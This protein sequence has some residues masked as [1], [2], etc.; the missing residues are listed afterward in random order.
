MHKIVEKQRLSEYVYSIWLEAAEIAQAHRPG[1]FVLLQLDLDYGERIPLTINDTDP[2]K[3][4]VRLTFQIVGRTTREMALLDEGDQI[5]AL[6]GPLGRP[7]HIQKRNHV[8]CVGGGIGMAPLLPIIR[9][10]HENGSR[11]TVVM[12]ARSAGLLIMEQ[13]VQA[14]ADELI[15][16]TDDG[17]KGRRCQVTEPLQEICRGGK[18]LAIPDEVFVIGPP[19]MMKFCCE[20]T[21]E[22][23]IPTQVS[24]NTIMVD[25]TGMCG[26]CRISVGGKLRF[27]CTDGPEFDGHQVDFDNLILRLSAY[28]GKENRDRELMPS[29]LQNRN[30]R[31]VKA[32]ESSR[33][34]E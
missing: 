15:I 6:L 19:I 3:G 8:V 29:R 27:V 30:C 12:G 23:R 31:S 11:V 33:I 9:A 16:C 5:A 20:V 26:S 4:L 28:K 18:G 17:G 13:E 25:G 7:S 24:L 14:Y 32:L 10:F 34:S 1:Q 2:E 22:F 21:R